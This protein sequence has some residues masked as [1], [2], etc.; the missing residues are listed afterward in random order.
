MQNLNAYNNMEI[1]KNSELF[2]RDY[3]KVFHNIQFENLYQGKLF[4][5][6]IMLNHFK[7]LDTL[8]LKIINQTENK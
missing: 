1:Q 3:N 7:E 5:N 2:N 4:W 6:T 8:A